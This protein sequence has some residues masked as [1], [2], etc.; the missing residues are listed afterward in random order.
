MSHK[1]A[2]AFYCEKGQIEVSVTTVPSCADAQENKEPHQQEKVGKSPRLR[3]SNALL[4]LEQ[5]L[6]H[7]PEQEK[8]LIKELLGEFAVLFPDVPGKTIF[9]FH[10]VDIGNALPVKQHP[11]RINP[12]KLTYMRNEV[13]YMLQNGIIEPSQSQWSSP[14][15]LVPKSDGIYRFCTDF[16][17]VNSVTKTDSYPIPQI[18]DCIDRIGHSR[19]VSKFDLLKGY[20][21]VA[22]FDRESLRSIHICD[23]SWS[24]P[25][26]CHALW[27]EECPCYFSADDL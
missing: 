17:K 10:D 7:L 2:E 6:Q 18:D 3:N 20:W 11:Y 5:K 23:S 8:M 19:Y 12:V 4:N 14:C 25:V 27:H 21:Q 1:H 16:R 26:L 22:T 9:T 24:I 13:E 15:V